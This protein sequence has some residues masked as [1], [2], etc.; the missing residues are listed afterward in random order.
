MTKCIQCQTET[1]NPKFCSR[2]CAVTYNNKKIAKRTALPP[3]KSYCL[4]C[5]K[6]I[7]NSKH[8]RKYCNLKCFQNHQF[9]LRSKQFEQNGIIYSKDK[10]DT[11]T[12]FLKRYFLKKQKNKCKI[13]GLVNNWNNHH[14]ILILDHINGIPNDWSITNLRLIC[15]N[16][17]S[18]L[19][20]YKRRNKNGGRY[21]RKSHNQESNPS[22]KGTNFV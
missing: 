12:S 21:Y 16:C 11:S 1:N 9:E 4:F 22:I 2:S 3:K 6:Q 13:C 15:P 7:I 17:D 14:L 18:Q 20:T 8:T 10:F 5:R 19:S